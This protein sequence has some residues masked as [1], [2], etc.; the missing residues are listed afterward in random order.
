MQGGLMKKTIFIGSGEIGYR[1]EGDTS[2]IDG[3]DGPHGQD[4]QNT[5]EGDFC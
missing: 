5:E 4:G 1:N 2:A 3:L